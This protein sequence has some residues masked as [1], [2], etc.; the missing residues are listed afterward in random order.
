MGCAHNAAAG[1]LLAA[2]ANVQ[3]WPKPTTS[4][5]FSA[6]SAPTINS[7]TAIT[8]APVR[9][10]SAALDVL[11]TAS[12]PTSMTLVQ[13]LDNGLIVSASSVPVDTAPR[14]YRFVA[15]LGFQSIAISSTT[16]FTTVIA[17]ATII[18]SK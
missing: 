1:A 16:S 5:N 8:P 10:T 15:P 9:D 11:V 6:R 3:V 7:S 17:S 18:Q 13:K 2:S 14:T 4:G 12:A